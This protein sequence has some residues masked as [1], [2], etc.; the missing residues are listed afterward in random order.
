MKIIRNISRILAGLVFMFSGFVKGIDPWG[1]T[2]KLMDY[3]EAFSLEW[4]D[5]T[6]LYLSVIVSALEFV[7]GFALIFNARPKLAAWGNL[8]FMAFFTPLTLYL[9]IANPVSDC[10]C[11]GD[12]IIMTNW[13]TF[14]KNIVLLIFAIIIFRERKKFSPYW[15]KLQQSV[16]VFIGAFILISLSW[17]SYQHLPIMDFRAWKVGAQMVE[18][19]PKPKVY[20]TYKNKE[21]G[22]TKEWLSDELPYDQPGFN[23][24]WEFV[25]QRTEEPGTPD[26]TILVEDESGN[27]V[28]ETIF[29]NKGYTFILIAHSLEKA[30][31][32]SMIDMDTF[33]EQ[34]KEDSV[35]FHAITGD[36]FEKS[37]TYKQQLN[38][39]YPF[40][41][42]DDITL[43]TVIRSN[44]G[45][46][47]LKDG[48]ILDK[49]HY[50]DFPK[51][52]H[53]KKEYLNSPR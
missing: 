52:Q 36:L 43:K 16:I 24:K 35:E 40:Y 7:I 18:E 28:S 2:Y 25:N 49:W 21:T 10:G 5:P 50:N 12:A 46:I 30:D 4:L 14:F 23:D 27:N 11:F 3:Y 32:E 42:A 47:L 19:I 13:E 44:P 1:F 37:S 6:A 8:L 20:L 48:L 34:C 45:L 39:D 22:E 38:L 41:L 15:N 31:E 33:Y 51:Y 29:T 9:A 53:F 17:Y 26:K